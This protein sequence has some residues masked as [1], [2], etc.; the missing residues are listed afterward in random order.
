MQNYDEKY[1]RAKANKRAGTIWLVLL[2]FVNVYYGTKVVTDGFMSLSWQ[3][4]VAVIGWS[5]YITAGLLMKF[6]GMDFPYYKYIMGY[7]YLLFFAYIAWTALDEVSYIFVLPM[8][9]SLV[10]YKDRKFI[11]RMMWATLFILFS[12]NLYKGWAKDMMEFVSSVDCAIQ[13]A[14]VIC[15]YSCTLM[16]I[17]HLEESD[18]A[19][20]GS[21][22]SNLERVVQTVEKV[23]VASNAV[24]DGVT[25]VRELAD[26]NKVGAENVVKDMRNLS[27][28]N[29]VLNDKTMSSMDMTTVIDTQVKNV[30]E[31]MEQVVEL[32]GGSIEHANTSSEEL[33]EVVD[34]TNKMAELSAE[35]EKILVEFKEEFENVKEETSTIEG[36]TSKTNLLALNASIEAARAGEAGRG[37][38][39][40]AEQI[41][42]LSSGTQ[43]SSSRIMSALS[44][45]EETSAKMLESISE[46]IG[47]IQINMDKVA[48]VNRS[49]TDITND[50]TAL[51]A[52]IKVVDSA[53][54]EVATSNITL[55]D[56]MKQVCEVME[57][58]TGRIDEAEVTTKTMLSKYE[59]SA[60]SAIDIENV[61]GK[62]ME[63]LG[64][65]GFM[66]V[67]DVREGMK[68]AIAFKDESGNTMSEYLGEVVDKLDTKVFV[69]VD[70]NGVELVDKKDKHTTCQLRIVVDNVLYCWDD[71]VIRHTKTDEK[72]SYKLYVESS[73]KVFNRRKYPRMPISNPCIINIEDVDRDFSGRMVNISANGFAFAIRDEL[74][75]KLKGR[76]IKLSIE[77]FM[78]LNGKPL[79]GYIIRSSNNEG[80]YI[81]GCRMPSDNQDIKDYVS[82]NY[83]E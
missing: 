67:Q 42:E 32:I 74:F 43:S 27:E 51:G 77:D 45:L 14:L 76:N 62:L 37:F 60:R 80:E 70:D 75:G 3:I 41:R 17:K 8:I 65:G 64:V 2:I 16:G 47:L 5:A 63:E 57:E 40:V 52:N 79:E 54:K 10:L 38:S 30:T 20:T 69:E 81:V 36:I 83:S 59:E 56:N 26:E 1:F 58:M 13:F 78:P 22:Q 23:K 61:V 12:S 55:V 25:V 44:H 29:G 18:G 49:V 4:T 15:C 53:V 82:M 9:A 7:G 31:L 72:G 35:V 73:T 46:T 68:I 50:A 48:N 34:T 11:K 28:N 6:K 19:L 33:I 24:V 21:I 71:V 39:V 66:G